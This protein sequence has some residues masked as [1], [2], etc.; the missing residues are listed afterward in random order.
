MFICLDN[1]GGVVGGFVF[2]FV[3]KLYEGF[4]DFDIFNGEELLIFSRVVE[5]ERGN[6]VI[7]NIMFLVL[8]LVR[9]DFSREFF[10]ELENMLV[11]KVSLNIFLVEDNVIN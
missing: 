1:W 2:F 9:L 10:V 6:C 5:C 8:V 3:L 4:M 7:G 11:S